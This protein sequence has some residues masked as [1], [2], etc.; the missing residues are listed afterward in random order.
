[1]LNFSLPSGF[2]DES[3]YTFAGKN[4]R[5][6][7]RST[8]ELGSSHDLTQVAQDFAN[9]LQNYL[10]AKPP[11]VSEVKTRADSV[12]YV[13]VT[14]QTAEGSHPLL[15]RAA[16]ILFQNGTAIQLSMSASPDDTQAAGEFDAVVQSARPA[17]PP[18]TGARLL[19]HEPNDVIPAQRYAGAATVNLPTDYQNVTTF[20]F[21]NSD[22]TRRLSIHVEKLPAAADGKQ[23]HGLF[24]A[25]T[26]AQDDLGTPFL[27]ESDH[28]LWKPRKSRSGAPIRETALTAPQVASSARSV[29]EVRQIGDARVTVH[30]H[31][32]GPD[33]GAQD[34]AQAVSESIE[35]DLPLPR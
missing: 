15:E 18:T 14:A 33:P 4:R 20:K 35:S 5:V 24:A 19:R 9:H 25:A 8:Q 11:E 28:H 2:H 12:Q 7:V 17:A 30:V 34:L 21:R 16:F 32:S 27:Y 29:D 6:I 23:S 3:E 13:T 1:M 10:G 31:S 22:G 26:T